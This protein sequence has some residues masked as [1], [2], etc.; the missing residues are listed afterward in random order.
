MGNYSNGFIAHRKNASKEPMIVPGCSEC[1]FSNDGFYY[2]PNYN[3]SRGVAISN[4]CSCTDYG[5][6][7]GVKPWPTMYDSTPLA[8]RTEWTCF[9]SFGD[10]GPHPVVRC[11]WRGNH[12]V[13]VRGNFKKVPVKARH[14]FFS[15]VAWE[16]FSQ[17]YIREGSEKER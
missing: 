8:R 13:P 17:F 15:N 1:A 16:F 2:T 4:G 10:C 7:C 12:E 5:A 6:D 11:T 9:Q 14:R 3:I